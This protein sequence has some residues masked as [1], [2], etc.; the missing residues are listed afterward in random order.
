MLWGTA[1]ASQEL[2]DGAL[3]PASV[4]A[5][6]T[7]LGG[8]ALGLLAAPGM[9]RAFP[10]ALRGRGGVVLG[11]AGASI[12]GY[13][14][15]FFLGVAE[16]GI[17]VGTILAVGSAPFFAGLVAL[18]LGRGRPTA[19]WAVSTLLAVA[20]LWLLVRPAGGAIVSTVGVLAA[21]AAGLSFGTFTVLSKDL[22]AAGLRRVDTVAVPFVLA[23]ALLLP[24]LAGGLVTSGGAGVLLEPRTLL[25]VLW[26]GLGA[27]AAGYLLFITG[28]TGV[29]AVAG[30]TLALMEP[31][32]ASLLGVALF[33]ERLGSVALLG[34]VMVTVALVVT[35]SRPGTDPAG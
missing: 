23:G 8:I 15:G 26:L 14:V 25:V 29:P 24:V 18:A 1:G 5:L 27:T 32:T 33:G 19:L 9:R 2:L 34:V 6:R 20:G 30:A 21:L 12:A 17:A 7:V 11:L 31:L 16:L 4:G 28:L 35:A 13:Q 22:L 10:A 3:D